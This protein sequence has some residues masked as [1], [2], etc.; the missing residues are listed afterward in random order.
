MYIIK[1]DNY[2]IQK[3]HNIETKVKCRRYNVCGVSF[4]LKTA[5]IFQKQKC[6]IPISNTFRYC[7]VSFS[8]QLY[9]SENN[10]FA[11]KISI[12]LLASQMHSYFKYI[13]V[14]FFSA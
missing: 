10:N 8:A 1:T 7:N 13:Q 4:F 9:I 6:A 2:M 12:P 14:K 5:S 11:R 3:I